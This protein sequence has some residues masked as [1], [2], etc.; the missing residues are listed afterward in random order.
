[1]MKILGGFLF[2]LVID[3]TAKSLFGYSS[4]LRFI[5]HIDAF[6]IFS[7]FFWNLEFSPSHSWCKSF[8]MAASAYWTPSD[9]LLFFAKKVPT[10]YSRSS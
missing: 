5:Y 10:T 7:P 9:V 8:C 4:R 3:R 1:M 2:I 6:G